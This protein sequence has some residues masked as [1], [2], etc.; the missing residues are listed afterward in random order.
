MVNVPLVMPLRVAVTLVVEPEVAVESTAPLPLEMVAITAVLLLVQVTRLVTSCCWALP[1]K[2][3][4]A[5]KTT[6]CPAAGLGVVVLM[7]MAVS[8][9]VLT[10]IVELAVRVPDVAVMVAVPGRVGDLRAA[11]DQT[12]L[13][14]GRDIRC[15]TGP[16]SASGQVL[17]AAVVEIAGGIDLLRAPLDDG[18]RGRRHGDRG[19]RG[20]HK[21]AATTSRQGEQRQ[22]YSRERSQKRSFRFREGMVKKSRQTYFSWHCPLRVA[23][24][25]CSREGFGQNEPVYFCV[26]QGLGHPELRE[27]CSAGLRRFAKGEKA[28]QQR[29]GG[30]PRAVLC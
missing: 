4:S 10:V 19:Q 23:T 16:A 9:P 13:T 6:V 28:R 26:H 29:C 3:P 8:G 5:V 20:I 11:C 25:N 1:V 27:A 15:G 2:V 17:G 30:T 7:A 21:E 12:A 14:D 22:G 24:K 18:R